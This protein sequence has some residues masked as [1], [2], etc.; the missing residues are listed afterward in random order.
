MSNILSRM[1]ILGIETSCDE[2]GAA[3]IDTSFN[4]YSNVVASQ[5]EIHSKY[6]GIVPEIASR[7]HIIKIYSVVEEAIS[8]SG[9]SFEDIEVIA[10]TRSPGLMGSL[11]VGVTFANGLAYASKKKVIGVNHL[12]GHLAAIRLSSDV[13]KPPFV[14]MVVSGG[15]TNIYEVKKWGEYTQIGTTLDD[16][17]GEAFDKVSRLLGFGYPG[18]P[19]IERYAKYGNE[20]LI[21]FPSVMPDRIDV[22]FSGLKTF[23]IDYLKKNP[24]NSEQDKFD[25]AASFQLAVARTLFERAV[26]A[27]NITGIKKILFSGGV[28]FNSYIRDYFLA[29]SV[30]HDL[31]IFF[32]EKR[33]C[34]D[35]AAM[36]AAASVRRIEEGSFDDVFS[37]TASPSSEL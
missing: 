29:H 33:F 17:A 10:V 7:N 20:D 5:T 18:G 2:T 30:D 23:V 4:V 13:L 12:E 15:H 19:E 9:L 16:A 26:L 34:T 25:I 8:K 24:I 37:L 36:I 32:P 27:S 22:S 21:K 31:E 11:L 28:A 3:V 6:G 1:Y 35:N 14:G